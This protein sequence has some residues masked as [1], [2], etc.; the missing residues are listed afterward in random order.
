NNDGARSEN[1]PSH[2]K[3]TGG[4][5]EKAETIEHAAAGEELE[6]DGGPG[7]SLVSRQVEAAGQVLHHGG[8]PAAAPACGKDEKPEQKAQSIS[9]VEPGG[10]ESSSVGN[11]RRTCKGPGAEAGH[12]AAQP[13]YQPGDPAAATKIFGGS[14][15]EPHHVELDQHHQQRIQG[16]H[17]VVDGINAAHNG[18]GADFLILFCLEK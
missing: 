4:G 6:Q 7:K 14:P 9:D 1:G 18:E 15:I 2:G 13:G 8:D 3:A 11:S 5:N 17:H 16:D 12:E 10:S